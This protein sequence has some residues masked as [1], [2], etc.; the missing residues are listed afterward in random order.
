MYFFLVIVFSKHILMSNWAN[1]AGKDFR[2]PA[3]NFDV[4][5]LHM[6]LKYI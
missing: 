3:N 4:C 2:N 1:N 6:L 5:D